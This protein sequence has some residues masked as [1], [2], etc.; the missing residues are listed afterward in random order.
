MTTEYQPLTLRSLGKTGLQV[1]AICAGGAPLGLP[2]VFAL[3]LT[4]EQAIDTLR[5][6][7]ASPI[8]FLDTGRSYGECERRIGI[9]IRE[10][11][12]LPPGF[13]LASKVDRDMQTGDFSGDQ[14]R[15]SLEESLRLLGLDRLPLVYLHDP[16]HTTFEAAMAPGGP[17]EVLVKMKE[18]GLC[19]HIGVAGGPID[20]MIRYVETGLFE[21][22]ISHNRYTLLNIEADPLW[23]TCVKYE[24]AALNA[25]AYGSGILVKGPSTYPRYGYGKASD[26]YIQ[27]ALRL[28]E[29]CT[30]YNVPLGAAALQFSIRDPRISATIVGM[31]H[32]DRVPE[33]VRLAEYLIPAELWTEIEELRQK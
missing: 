5:A 16:E 32:P 28:E 18:E 10:M 23:D 25:A 20:M 7:F 8:S 24:V 4:E 14:M 27:R 19:D 33:T 6:I 26:E 11:G 22:A 2:Q 17:V 21:A 9:V 3:E 29:A 12:G 13:V 31:S 1:P 15:R 30:R